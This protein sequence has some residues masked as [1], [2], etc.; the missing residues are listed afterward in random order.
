M[1]LDV[2]GKEY[3]QDFTLSGWVVWQNPVIKDIVINDGDEVKAG[4]YIK[5]AAGGWGTLDGFIS[6]YSH[7]KTECNRKF[8]RQEGLNIIG[9]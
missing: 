4:A 8:N 1:L 3:R 7:S 9:A 6:E 2:N 5:T